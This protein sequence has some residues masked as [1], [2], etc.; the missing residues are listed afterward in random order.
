MTDRE[1]R[2]DIH[3]VGE[4]AQDCIEPRLRH[5]G[6]VMRFC[7]KDRLPC[8]CLVNAGNPTRTV[9]EDG[10]DQR[11]I[12]CTPTP[13]AQAFVDKRPATSPVEQ[14]D[15]TRNDDDADGDRNR[16]AG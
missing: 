2:L 11:R 1:R 7:G 16:I 12:V 6:R 3:E 13:P 14:I 9:R 10:V 8:R 15:I 4:D 5:R